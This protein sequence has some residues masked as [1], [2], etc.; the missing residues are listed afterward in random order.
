MDRVSICK[1]NIDLKC[2]CVL[3]HKEIN[4]HELITYFLRGEKKNGP[5]EKNQEFVRKMDVEKT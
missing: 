5:E 1:T 3:C 2:Y 4:F